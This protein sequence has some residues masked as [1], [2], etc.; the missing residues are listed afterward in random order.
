MKS[1]FHPSDSLQW[2]SIQWESIENTVSSIQHRIAKATLEGKRR[3]IRNLQRMLVK[4]LSARLKAVRQ[5]A[6]ENIGKEIP[7]VDGELWLTPK[8]KLKAAF[9]L[10]AR[11]KTNPLREISWPKGHRSSRPLKIPTLTDRAKQVIWHL[12][13]DPIVHTLSDSTSYGLGSYHNC[14][15]AHAQLKVILSR[16]KAPQW[17]LGGTIR[18]CSDTSSHNWLLEYT[19]METK[20]LGNWLKSGFLKS[21]SESYDLGEV[22]STTLWNH[23][24]NGLINKLQVL[25]VNYVRYGENFIVTARSPQQ[26]QMVMRTVS[27][28]LKPRG[29]DL[30]PEQTKIVNIYD[31]FHFLGWTF[32]KSQNGMLLCKVSKESIKEYKWKLRDTLKNSRNKP[33]SAIIAELNLLLE[34]RFCKIL[35]NPLN[36]YLYK[37]LWRWARKRHP[38]QPRSWIYDH[39]WKILEGRRTFVAMEKK[40]ES[41]GFKSLRAKEPE[42]I[43]LLI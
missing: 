17:I 14:W 6:Q 2:N 16:Q 3:K 10:R 41:L 35:K 1:L 32:K 12:A 21:S 23:T 25:N 33:T 11:T 24:L 31:G 34:N 36:Q 43:S 19:P 13:L 27:D 38:R 30:H 26:L 15:D 7:G 40:K 42:I 28:F 29:L 18:K 4:S 37:L 39:Y 9:S 20:I 8:R 22:F 5:V